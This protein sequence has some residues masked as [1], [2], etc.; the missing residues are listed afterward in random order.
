MTFD[1]LVYQSLQGTLINPLPQVE[2]LFEEGKPCEQWY[3]E[4]YD[5]H[6]RLCKRLGNDD[7]TDEDVELIINSM[8]SIQSKIAHR[9]Y[10]YGALYGFQPEFED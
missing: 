1:E 3:S 10:Y 8:F 6:I 7:D 9:M 2:N 5:A 4:V